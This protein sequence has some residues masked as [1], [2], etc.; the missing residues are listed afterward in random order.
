[1][2]PGRIAQLEDQLWGTP[3][4]PPEVPPTP[5]EAE[6]I[7]LIEH[8]QSGQA[9]LVVPKAESPQEVFARAGQ[10][11]LD[12]L[13]ASIAGLRE[14]W[15]ALSKE[16]AA[17][18]TQIAQVEERQLK[19]MEALEATKGLVIL[20]PKQPIAGRQGGRKAQPA[21]KRKPTRRSL[22]DAG[23]MTHWVQQTI[24]SKGEIDKHKLLNLAVQEGDRLGKQW[25]PM[26][27]AKRLGGLLTAKVIEQPRPGLYRLRVQEKV[28]E[29]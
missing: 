20:A 17:V 2:I 11:V 14:R 27:V 16:I 4:L 24:A 15:D 18:G 13:E 10:A 5:E 22:Q 26:H 23:E 7:A 1:M 19:V 21:P 3:P 9:A 8:G 28:N 29:G 12:A 25:L 6:A